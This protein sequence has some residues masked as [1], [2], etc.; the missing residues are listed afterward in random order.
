MVIERQHS[1]NNHSY[2]H[3][4]RMSSNSLRSNEGRPL[5]E[6]Q[7]QP[8]NYIESAG[9]LC[10][11][12]TYPHTYAGKRTKSFDDVY[13]YL[14]FENLL[15]CTTSSQSGR[16]NYNHNG[17]SLPS[18]RKHNT[19]V[20]NTTKVTNIYYPNST[21]MSSSNC[22]TYED[23]DIKDKLLVVSIAKDSPCHFSGLQCFDEI[24][25]VNGKCC[26]GWLVQ[27]VVNE[28]TTSNTT[29]LKV[30]STVQAA[31]YSLKKTSPRSKN[32]LG[33]YIVNGTIIC[34]EGS[35]AYDSGLRTGQVVLS[36]SNVNV[37]GQ[38]DG[39]IWEKI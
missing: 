10:R 12:N 18:I 27:D 30:Q 29:V 28:M 26:Q 32:A 9:R 21:H 15:P 2:Q 7:G 33:I 1:T 5:P 37:F 11:N 34:K 22:N 19:K 25:E 31:N 6:P 3:S 14:D 24:L 20:I 17:K 35:V 36:V 4:S 39:Q 16:D 13:D 8:E 38:K 23:I